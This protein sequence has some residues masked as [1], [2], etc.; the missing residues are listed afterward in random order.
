LADAVNETVA[1]PLSIVA[2]GD[3]GEV[4]T[5]EGVIGPARVAADTPVKFSAIA[6]KLYATPFV[7]PANV[8]EVAGEITWHV[9]ALCP[10]AAL[11]AVTV[12]LVGSPPVPAPVP[13]A[14][15]TDPL[16]AVRVSVGASGAVGSQ[17]AIKVVFTNGV[18]VASGSTEVLPVDH[19][20]KV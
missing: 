13:T 12:K 7:R 2:E 9:P 4:G 1:L 16:D 10:V 18:I 19:A 20:P 11:I 6:E 8:H 14:I 17:T 5:V 3:V 15:V